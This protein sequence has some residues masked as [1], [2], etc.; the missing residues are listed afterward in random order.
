MSDIWPTELR[1]SKDRQRLTVTFND[2]QNK[3]DLLPKCYVCFRPRQKYR[4]MGR[5]RS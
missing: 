4:A 5:G 3:F 2:G 1:V